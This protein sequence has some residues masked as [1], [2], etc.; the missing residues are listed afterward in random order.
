[1]SFTLLVSLFAHRSRKK[2][3]RERESDTVRVEVEKEEETL[4]GR[5]GVRERVENCFKEREQAIIN[6]S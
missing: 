2:R 6:K 1:M 5:Q 3:E 4:R